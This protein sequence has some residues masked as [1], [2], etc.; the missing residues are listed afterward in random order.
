MLLFLS[1]FLSYFRTNN[2]EKFRKKNPFG[3][4]KENVRI[5][6]D[7]LDC[8]DVHRDLGSCLRQGQMWGQV[9][10][11]C[12]HDTDAAVRCDGEYPW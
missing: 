7:V 5:W 10:D 11:G 9:N 2:L 6:L 12:T 1:I 3:S 8:Q 4:S